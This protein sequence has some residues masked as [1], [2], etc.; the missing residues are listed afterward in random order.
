M[1]LRISFLSWCSCF[2]IVLLLCRFTTS[3][4][5]K[6]NWFASVELDGVAP[7]RASMRLLKVAL[8]GSSRSKHTLVLHW[9]SSKSML[10]SCAFELPS[11][12]K[13]PPQ[14]GMQCFY[15]CHWL[16]FPMVLFIFPIMIP[17]SWLIRLPQSALPSPSNSFGVFHSRQVELDVRRMAPRLSAFNQESDQP[18]ILHEGARSEQTTR[19]GLEP[20]M[21]IYKGY[22]QQE[23]LNWTRFTSSLQGSISMN[24]LVLCWIVLYCIRLDWIGLDCIGLC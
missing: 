23:E 4:M 2:L 24:C 1:R 3:L 11:K 17:H 16:S 9:F 6:L 8:L 10:A 22:E 21:N 20:A 18:W 14:L 7:K 5:I 19:G 13:P 15:T 12:Q